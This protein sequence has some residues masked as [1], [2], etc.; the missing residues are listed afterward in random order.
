[1]QTLGGLDSAVQHVG[2]T[3]ASL[4]LPASGAEPL[5]C[6]S[7]ARVKAVGGFDTRPVLPAPSS[8][9]VEGG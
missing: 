1:M 2:P 9:L 5:E 4:G 3:E 7:S 6:L 8:W